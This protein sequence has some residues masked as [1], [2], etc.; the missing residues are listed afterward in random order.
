MKSSLETPSASPTRVAGRKWSHAS[1]SEGL[2]VSVEVGA[3]SLR[4]VVLLDRHHRSVGK[5]NAIR[6]GGLCAGSGITG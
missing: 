2:D 1:A 5:K 4:S 6:H 3:A